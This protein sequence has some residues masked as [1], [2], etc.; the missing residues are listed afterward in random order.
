MM[1]LAR[2]L[3]GTILLSALFVTVMAARSKPERARS[4]TASY[5]TTRAEKEKPPAFVEFT[6][7][8]V[9]SRGDSRETRYKDGPTVEQVS[10]SDGTYLLTA[11]SKEILGPSVSEDIKSFFRI[12]KNIKKHP[13]MVRQEQIVGLTAYVIRESGSNETSWSERWMA[14]ETGAVPLKFVLHRPEFEF[15]VEAVALQFDTGDDLGIPQDR[16]IS[17][18]RVQKT[19]DALRRSGKVDIAAAMERAIKQ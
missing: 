8:R 12:R 10:D 11:T 13:S 17:F 15:V 4:F 1:R 2:I 3:F 18:R 7:R 5:L 14:P 16:T 9:N 19:V 6:V